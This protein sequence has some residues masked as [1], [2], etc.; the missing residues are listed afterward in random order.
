MTGHVH[1]ENMRLYAE[2][3]AETA[4]PWL[5]WES[6]SQ[7]GSWAS[8]RV[9]PAWY[10]DMRYRRRP[11]TIN[12]NGIEVPEPC[13]T[14]PARNSTYWVP[15]TADPCALAW[16]CSWDN[17]EVDRIRLNFGIVHLTREAAEIHA[18]ALLSFTEIKS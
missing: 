17:C 13:R 6:A 5:R 12:I 18:R 2:D 9:H 3:A 7:N 8:L 4:E 11:R 15:T 14:A 1:A 10:S 16:R